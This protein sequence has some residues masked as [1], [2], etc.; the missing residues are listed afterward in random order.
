M[1]PLES[2]RSPP[3]AHRPA[4][5]VRIPKHSFSCDRVASV[6]KSSPPVVQ[7]QF[8]SRWSCHQAGLERDCCRESCW[9]CYRACQR[10]KCVV[11]D[12]PWLD[13]QTLAVAV[14]A[15]E[16]KRPVAASRKNTRSMCI[17]PKS[18]TTANVTAQH[19]PNVGKASASPR[20]GQA[21]DL[22]FMLSHACCCSSHVPS[23]NLTRIFCLVSARSST[24]S[25][26]RRDS[27]ALGPMLATRS[28]KLYPLCSIR[29]P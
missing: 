3:P 19:S 26:P 1:S 5:Q 22:R 25:P 17:K 4:L 16:N 9:A 28:S 20:P 23:F 27:V 21:R 15:E 13:V 6:W 29:K 2:Q 11:E 10:Q 7:E 12:P 8:C 24:R 14:Y 18:G